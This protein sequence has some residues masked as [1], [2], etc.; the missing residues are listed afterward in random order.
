[1]PINARSDLRVHDP[2]FGLEIIGLCPGSG[3]GQTPSP[4]TLCQLFLSI[5]LLNYCDSCVFLF[6]KTIF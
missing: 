2:D 6:Y 4:F 5:S 1:M 3:S